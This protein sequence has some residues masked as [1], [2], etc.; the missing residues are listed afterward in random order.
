MALDE[1][2][3]GLGLPPVPV[4]AGYMRGIDRDLRVPSFFG[5]LIATDES[6]PKPLARALAWIMVE[7]RASIEAVFAD[8]APG[9]QPVSVPIDPT[10]IAD[11]PIPLHPGARQYYATAG[12]GC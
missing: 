6:L 11:T 7:R 3:S 4:E 1:I 5:Y 8:F 2:E 12:L 10:G 9:R